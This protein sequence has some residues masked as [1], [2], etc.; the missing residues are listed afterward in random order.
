[1]AKV[2]KYTILHKSDTIHVG[3]GE[4]PKPFHFHPVN[5]SDQIQACAD[6]P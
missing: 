2:Q 4:E 5:G 6:D 1:M 3:M